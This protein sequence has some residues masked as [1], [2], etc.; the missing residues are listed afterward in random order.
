M[1]TPLPETVDISKVILSGINLSFVS[2]VVVHQQLNTGNV[3]WLLTRRHLSHQ[4]VHPEHQVPHHGKE[5]EQVAGVAQFTLPGVS[6]A[7]Q[8]HPSS[9]HL[10]LSVGDL[11]GLLPGVGCLQFGALL[12]DGI[13]LGLEGREVLQEVLVFP[14]QHGHRGSVSAELVRHRVL[15][16]Q[17]PRENILA[18]VEILV[19]LSAS[20][21]HL[22]SG[23]DQLA[24]VGPGV[25]ERILPLSDG[26]S[27]RVTNTD[28][29]VRDLVD[30][31]HSLAPDSI[32][33]LG[34]LLEP[35]NE[36]SDMLEVLAKLVRP[37][38]DLPLSDP[39]L[40]IVHLSV[41]HEQLQGV[42]QLSSALGGKILQASI[43]LV[44]L[45]NPD[46]DGL[47]LR[48]F[49]SNQLSGSLAKL[50]DSG[51][52]VL[53]GGFQNF[54]FLHQILCA[55]LVLASV[56]HHHVE[57][58]LAHPGLGLVGVVHELLD[59][60]VDKQ[61]L[62]SGVEQVLKSGPLLC[63]VVQVSLELISFGMTLS[64]QLLSGLHHGIDP[65]LVAADQ[66]KLLVSPQILI[67]HVSLKLESLLLLLKLQLPRLNGFLDL[68]QNL[69]SL[70]LLDSDLINILGLHSLQ[71]GGLAVEISQLLSLDKHLCLDQLLLL[72]HDVDTNKVLQL[73]HR[74]SLYLSGNI[75]SEGVDIVT[76]LII[77]IS[78]LG[79]E[80]SLALVMGVLLKLVEL[81][82]EV[83]QLGGDKLIHLRLG[84]QQ[85]IARL[86]NL[87]QPVL[88]ADYL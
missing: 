64:N 18:V 34:E 86:Q 33:I 59:L 83:I 31:S 73:L 24:Q 41:Q 17:D 68:L 38:H 32:R 77:Q 46:I 44:D 7:L 23:V 13:N 76:R 72:D 39:L 70:V 21:K 66:S 67:L 62:S 56:L 87:L 65:L 53:D 55:K 57:L 63:Q 75:L 20:L 27:V 15:L 10:P 52:K 71:V 49:I 19:Q 61:S 40:E 85:G 78:S 69:V 84:I 6:H 12:L 2:L 14:L 51:G 80:Q 8:F 47:T 54:M 9:D 60:L 26:S 25:V 30:S 58:L 82:V 50:A 3:S 81:R 4:V 42:I 79:I 29:T 36:E 28:Q 5:P 35:L 43:K 22:V 16:L 88:I 45:T 11:H 48:M 1:K 37:C 74:L